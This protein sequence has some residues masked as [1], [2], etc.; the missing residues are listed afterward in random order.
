MI[1]SEIVDN[2]GI[3]WFRRD[4]RVAGNEA[5]RENWRQSNGR[6]LGVFFFDSE[7]LKRADFSSNRFAFFL[8]T[9]SELK[10]ELKMMGGDLLVIDCSPKVGFAQLFE[11]FKKSK[12]GMPSV[13][14]YGRDYEPFARKRDQEISSFLQAQSVREL[15][16]RDH[17]L[18]EPL[19]LLK[20]D[21]SFYQIY[22]PFAR[23]W[24]QKLATPEIAG[25]LRKQSSA[26]SHFE[27]LKSNKMESIF[28]LGWS[29]LVGET[30]FPFVDS[31]ERFRTANQKNVTIPIPKG[32]FFEGFS[33]LQE[34]S[35]SVSKYLE[36]RDFP[37]LEGTSRLS[38][39]LKNGSLTTSQ[40]IHELGLEGLSFEQKSGPTQYLKEIAWREFYYSI[41]F[42]RPDVEQQAF[43]PQYRDLD[44]QN[45]P[46]WFER[47]KSGKTGF[48]IVD[49]GMRE[50]NTTG[51]MHNRVRMIVASFL[52]KDLLIDWKWGE[53]YFMK[54]LLDGDLAPNNGGWQWAA[55]TGCDPQPYFRVF[56]PWLQGKKF[57]PDAAYIKRF[58]PELKNAHPKLIHDS[59]GDRSAYRYPKPVVDHSVQRNLAIELYKKNPTLKT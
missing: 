55:S 1:K 17:L 52:T 6:T 48:P 24:F 4:L 11:F 42:H 43:L 31:L 25:R 8:N 49:A 3:H 27:K 45:D 19:E 58:V 56:N 46:E 30:E 2:W 41:L 12:I 13:V 20:D 51:F 53:N 5:L 10:G 40:I 33:R 44:W 57:D 54:M 28:K 50:L 47:W 23:K 29:E 7:F 39:F 38:M 59:E 16:L 9:L 36:C 15:C 35:D 32:G 18:I 22:S 26:S 21:Q 34:Y 14:S 37:S